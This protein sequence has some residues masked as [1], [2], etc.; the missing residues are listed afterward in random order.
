MRNGNVSV[1]IIGVC[2]CLCPC[3]VHAYALPT[4]IYYIRTLDT[5]IN[6]CVQSGGSGNIEPNRDDDDDDGDDSSGICFLMWFIN[7]LT[8]SH[9]RPHYSMWR[10]YLVLMPQWE[11]ATSSKIKTNEPKKRQRWREKKKKKKPYKESIEI[12]CV[13]LPECGTF[14]LSHTQTALPI[15]IWGVFFCT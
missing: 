1:Y 15:C 10:I 12:P 5:Q 2:V 4:F 11:A 3:P 9:M 13:R 8:L 6:I 14:T 7:L